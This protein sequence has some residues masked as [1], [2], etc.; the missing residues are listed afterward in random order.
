MA[1]V[2]VAIVGSIILGG[3]SM[4]VLTQLQVVKLSVNVRT[5][6]IIRWC[7][8]ALPYISMP[9]LWVFFVKRFISSRSE[10]WPVMTEGRG[11]ES[12]ADRPWHIYFLVAA[13][14]CLLGMLVL[15]VMRMIVN[16]IGGEPAHAFWTALCSS[17]VWSGIVF[18]T[19]GFAA[20]QLDSLPNTERPRL[21]RIGMRCIPALIQGLLTTLAVYIAFMHT[22]GGGSLDVH[23]LP[24][25]MQSKLA[26]YSLIG[27]FL[28]V[29]LNLA[30]GFC[31][32]K[33][34]RED[35][36]RCAERPI[37]IRFPQG[38]V[39]GHTKNVSAQGVLVEIDGYLPDECSNIQITDGND[40]S[41]AG[42]IVT[43][44]GKD[45]HIKVADSE[46]WEVMR[47]GFEFSSPD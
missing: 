11:Y 28:G 47:S 32:L 44:Q 37:N 42:Y 16:Q 7:G 13:S 2:I 9:I 35:G 34:R 15:S 10:A 29:S 1:Y 24:E 38:S 5:Q 4:F 30:F 27:F 33:Q 45:I 40:H 18:M 21:T 19:A 22:Y 8:Y 6:D 31:K 25:A 14:S 26:V 39:R 17:A 20:Y 3:L 12:I 41:V 23:R 36:R 43:R 46:A